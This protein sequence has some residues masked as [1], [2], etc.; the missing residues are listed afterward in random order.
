MDS[1]RLHKRRSIRLPGYDYRQSGAYFVTLCTFERRA[2]LGEASEHEIKLSPLGSKISDC[3]QSIPTV[4]PAV[5]LDA[6]VVM[7][8]HI[9][10]IIWIC[11]DNVHLPENTENR[12]DHPNAMSG[13][14]GRMINLFKG[15][16]TRLLSWNERFH[17]KRLWQR[18][19]Y[20][21]I[22][23]NQEDLYRIRSYI[24][25]NPI[26]LSVDREIKGRSTGAP[27]HELIRTSCQD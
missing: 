4:N 3:W 12:S 1:N 20:E 9:H 25:D 21:H 18:G 22:I 6:F 5:E 19:Y 16:C 11:Q 2:L 23:R 15:R 27:L 13:S 24:I 8:E 17:K 14:L 7:P 26:A 10:G